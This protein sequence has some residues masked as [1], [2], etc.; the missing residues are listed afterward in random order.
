MLFRGPVTPLKLR[1]P[2]LCYPSPTRS[3]ASLHS[4]QL[5]ATVSPS[6]HLNSLPL[7]HSAA[8]TAHY[9]CR[10]SNWEMLAYLAA[11]NR[12]CTIS[13]LDKRISR[14][15]HALLVLEA[16][17]D[18]ASHVMI[19]RIGLSPI[20]AIMSVRLCT[21]R[22][23]SSLSSKSGT[24]NGEKN[25]RVT[26]ETRSLR[27]HEC[28]SRFAGSDSPAHAE[29]NAPLSRLLASIQDA[30]RTTACFKGDDGDIKIIIC[31]KPE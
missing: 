18:S 20:L 15:G 7:L 12:I 25:A 21:V 31:S 13:R 28:W 22:C 6:S 14:A 23:G 9:T 16:G 8:R 4:S 2:A 24:Y 17:A 27:R 3:K 5:A 29:L 1:R 11:P 10:C 30:L 19:N 26:N